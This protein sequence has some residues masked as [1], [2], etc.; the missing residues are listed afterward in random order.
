MS[1]GRGSASAECSGEDARFAQLYARCYR[2]IRAYCSRRV[3][4]DAVDDAVAETFLTVW[5]RLD[6]V[7]AGE[8][9]LVWTY[10]VAYRVIG[11]QWRSTT[12]RGRLQDRLRSVGLG[13]VAAADESTVD[14]DE[15]RLVLVALSRLGDT[16]AEVLRLVAWEQ[17]SIADIAAVLGIQPDAARQRLHRARRNLARAYGRLQF[18]P[19]STPDAP[20]GGAR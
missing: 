3:A 4:A 5:R 1:G 6:E 19:S 12:R 15:H 14:G 2:P 13:P 18:L 8:E 16:D 20:T 11:H 9:A 17:L 7:P 10:G